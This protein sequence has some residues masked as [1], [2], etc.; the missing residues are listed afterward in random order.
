MGIK[1]MLTV[2]F[3][4]TVIHIFEGIVSLTCTNADIFSRMVILPFIEEASG[5]YTQ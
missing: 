2:H 5:M 1:Y 3:T 4:F